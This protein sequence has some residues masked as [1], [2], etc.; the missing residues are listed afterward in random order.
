MDFGLCMVTTRDPNDVL[1]AFTEAENRG[2]TYV[3]LWDSPYNFMDIYPVF[4]DRSDEHEDGRDG[5]IR[6]Q[7]AHAPPERDGE[8]DGDHRHALG[9]PRVPGPRAR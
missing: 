9:R 4:R 6:D 7:P 5:P 2:F 1:Y 8:R 3:G